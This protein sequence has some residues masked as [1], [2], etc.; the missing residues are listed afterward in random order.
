M[1]SSARTK[2]VV[3]GV[4][5]M[6]FGGVFLAQA[7]GMTY[8]SK[9]FPLVVCSM[10]IIVN[11]LIALRAVFMPGLL[12]KE[13]TRFLPSFRSIIVMVTA[14]IYIGLIPFLGFYASSFLCILFISVVTT[15]EPV[16][17]RSLMLTV[18]ADVIFMIVVY[19]IFSYT[20][21]STIPHGILI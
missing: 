14:V 3:L 5:G 10:I 8:P 11:A 13:S 16:T 12:T 17:K 21:Q 1:Q 18:V 7:Y 4:I 20:L 9:V 15:N 6:T 2:D 19:I